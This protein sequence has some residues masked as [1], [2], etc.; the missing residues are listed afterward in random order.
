MFAKAHAAF[1]FSTVRMFS[2]YPPKPPLKRG[3]ELIIFFLRFPRGEEY[4]SPDI[5]KNR[6]FRLAPRPRNAPAAT[7]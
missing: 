5:P 1:G 7:L 6:F 3:R 2:Y 4:L